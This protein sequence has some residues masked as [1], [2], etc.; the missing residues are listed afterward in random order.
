MAILDVG[1][2]KIWRGSS[3]SRDA[4]SGGVQGIYS[5]G[6][7]VCPLVLLFWAG[8]LPFISL[9]AAVVAAAAGLKPMSFLLVAGDM[10]YGVMNECVDRTGTAPSPHYPTL[11]DMPNTSLIP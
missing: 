6:Q 8:G 3:F 4:S 1:A 2:V 9:G 5:I 7:R 11:V 10:K